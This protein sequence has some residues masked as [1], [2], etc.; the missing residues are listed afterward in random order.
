MRVLDSISNGL[1]RFARKKYIISLFIMFI[2]IVALLELSPIGAFRLKE[3]SGGIGMLD[4]EFGYSQLQV[5][6]LLDSI[7]AAGRQLYSRMLGLDFIFAVIFMLFQSLLLTVLLRKTAV[8]QYLQKLNILPFVRSALDIVENIFLL[9]ILFN[10]PGHYP[11]IIKISSAI[12]ILKWIVYYA[13]ITVAFTLG[14]LMSY[15][16]I[17]SKIQRKKCEVGGE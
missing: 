11:N 7:G 14:T 10:Y 9:V 12:T 4:M 5:Y 8:N 16:S 1:Q 3:M 17:L 15:Q 6:S 13:I 2:T